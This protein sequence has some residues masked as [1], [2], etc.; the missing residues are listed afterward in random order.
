MRIHR[1]SA[2]E[3]AVVSA[4][5]RDTYRDHFAGLWQAD[6]LSTWLD[7]QF[8]ESLIRNDIDNGSA[9]YLICAD[10]DNW[11]GY[12]KLAW[13]QGVPA[14]AEHGALLQKIYFRAAAT[15]SGFGTA[16]LEACKAQ[17]RDAGEACLW[18]DVLQSND[19]ARRFYER[20]GFVVIGERAFARANESLPMWV[21]HHPLGPTR[22]T[23]DR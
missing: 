3:A 23:A 22:P 10:D 4:L 8:G 9:C 13:Q 20:N 16:L 14:R 21:M 11:V 2:S 18:L 5:G 7:G 6:E 15:R 17:A 12:A 1:A 19:R